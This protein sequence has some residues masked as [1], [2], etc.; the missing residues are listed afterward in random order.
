MG[1]AALLR[2]DLENTFGLPLDFDEP[3]AFVDGQGE[4][5]L[6][7]NILSCLHCGDGNQR[8]PVV[9]RAADDGIDIFS[10]QQLAEIGIAF[11]AWE[12]FLSGRKVTGV[13]VTDSNDLTVSPGISRVA[14]ALPATADKC[15]VDFLAGRQ[16]FRPSPSLLSIAFFD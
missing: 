7:V 11:G 16:R 6:A 2:A 14:L 12:K 8:V 5:L 1:A 4:R 3:L 13:N 9:N 10:L 15:E